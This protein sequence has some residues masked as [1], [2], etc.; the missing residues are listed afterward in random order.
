MSWSAQFE[1][2]KPSQAIPSNFAFNVSSAS[3]SA[4]LRRP[5][6]ALNK[7]IDA[8]LQLA[9]KGIDAQMGLARG[10]VPDA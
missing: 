2:A 4:L 1:F 3:R 9:A 6:A 10:G 8:W 7:A 5:G